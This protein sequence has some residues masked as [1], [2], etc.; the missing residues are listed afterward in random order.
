MTCNRPGTGDQATRGA[1][2]AASIQTR[3]DAGMPLGR[4]VEK[5]PSAYQN[6]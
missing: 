4:E 3:V 2:L 6:V 5:R 1:S